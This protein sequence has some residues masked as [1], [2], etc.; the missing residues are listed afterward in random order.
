MTTLQCKMAKS[1][2]N[3][4]ETQILMLAQNFL[5]SYY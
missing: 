4:N 5:F 3:V 1:L 2:V